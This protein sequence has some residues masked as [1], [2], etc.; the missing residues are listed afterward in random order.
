MRHCYD[1]WSEVHVTTWRNQPWDC[2]SPG[3]GSIPK[4]AIYG[5]VDEGPLPAYS[6]EK[7]DALTEV[8]LRQACAG[9]G[10]GE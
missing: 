9:K 10:I 4:M 2:T 3:I 1:S 8:A 6:V 7:R 5:N